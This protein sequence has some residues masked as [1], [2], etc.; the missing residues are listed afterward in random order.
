MPSNVA[1]TE[2]TDRPEPLHDALVAL[3]HDAEDRF[4]AR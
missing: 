4:A 3:D 2:M 1:T